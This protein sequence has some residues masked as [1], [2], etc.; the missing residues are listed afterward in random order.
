MGWHNNGDMKISAGSIYFNQAKI[1]IAG[2]G[3]KFILSSGTATGDI[4]YIT[5]KNDVTGVTGTGE[6][7]VGPA[8]TTP[9]SFNLDAYCVST[10]AKY[11]C[12]NKFSG[13][14][15]FECSLNYFPST[16][17]IQQ[18]NNLSAGLSFSNAQPE[19]VGAVASLLV[20]AKYRFPR[21]NDTTD[22]IVTI[23]SLIGNAK[24]ESIDD[25]ATGTGYS[26]A[27]QPRVTSGNLVGRSYAVFTVH[28]V[29]AGSATPISV[30]F[31]NA[32]PLD[33]DGG[34]T[35]K[36]FAEINIG[37]GAAM[38][39]MST[40]SDISVLTG[41][42]TNWY[43]AQ[44]S[45]GIERDNIDTVSYNNMFTVSNSDVSSFRIKYGTYTSSPST[46]TRQFSLYMRGFSYP[47]VA[48]LPVKLSSFTAN[49]KN[50]K[51]DLKWNTD[52]EE[53]LSHFIVER[54]TNGSDYEEIGMV[55]AF[56][57]SS[58]QKNYLFSDNVSSLPAGI[59]YYRL[60]S[61]NVNGKQEFSEVRVVRIGK[62]ENNVAILTY[63]N[64]ATTEVRI[65]LHQLAEQ[66]SGIPAFYCQWN[67]GS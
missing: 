54:S 10:S 66:K 17:M 57:N 20:G 50:E 34:A 5:F 43:G 18:G 7:N 26:F 13:S 6:L 30:Q 47:I 15:S 2:T 8:V 51:T 39:Y 63:P 27:F 59:V 65:T 42:A 58:V 3:S 4:D 46:S 32:T 22:A 64:P 61:V 11:Q 62:Q 53:S 31:I 48:L 29:K 25:N 44:N 12:N 52:S 1:Q 37:E 60:R 33:I 55:F 36:E 19:P 23:D 45:L 41:L 21:V 40:A 67:Y 35:L 14:Q 16:F 38:N 56:G 28:F 9:S 24:V 49:L